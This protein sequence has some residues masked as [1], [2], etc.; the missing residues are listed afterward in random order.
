MVVFVCKAYKLFLLFHEVLL[1]F[2]LACEKDQTTHV[3]VI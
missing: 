1:C 2:D 3:Q